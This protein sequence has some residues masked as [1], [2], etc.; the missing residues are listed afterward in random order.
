MHFKLKNPASKINWQIL[1]LQAIEVG[2]I[3]YM[4]EIRQFPIL[5]QIDLGDVESLL[6]FLLLAKCEVVPLV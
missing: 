5:V 6:T 4:I 3:I 2:F 1:L